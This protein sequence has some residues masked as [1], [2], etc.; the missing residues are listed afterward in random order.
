MN[1]KKMTEDKSV[2]TITNEDMLLQL[3]NGV[4]GRTPFTVY[5]FADDDGWVRELSVLNKTDVYDFDDLETLKINIPIEDSDSLKMN[6]RSTIEFYN[7]FKRLVENEM[8][9][10]PNV[11]IF[12]IK[13]IGGVFAVKPKGFDVSSIFQ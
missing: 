13:D 6:R 11:A 12:V 10:V 5:N 8:Q 1:N 2:G 3:K 7:A 4:F 9:P